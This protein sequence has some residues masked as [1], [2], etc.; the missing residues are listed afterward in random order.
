[1]DVLERRR[2][3]R[4]REVLPEPAGEPRHGVEAV[5][6]RRGEHVGHLAEVAVDDGHG[7][8]GAVHEEE[9]D[10]GETVRRP[11]IVGGEDAGVDQQPHEAAEEGELGRGEGQRGDEVGQ[12]GVAVGMPRWTAHRR[13]MEVR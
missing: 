8:G 13:V 7:G 2:R 12:R 10:R 9:G 6:R 4:S 5:P 11:C 1:V 3:R